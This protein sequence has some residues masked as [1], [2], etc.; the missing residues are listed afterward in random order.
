MPRRGE[1]RSGEGLQHEDGQSHVYAATVPSCRAYDPAFSYEVAVIVEDG[2]R[3]MLGEGENAFYYVT[4]YNENYPQ[5]A[6]PAGVE[7]G[8][9][10]GMYRLRASSLGVERPCVQLLGSGSLLREVLAAAE[11]LE[12]EFG[13]AADVWSVTSFGE[14]RKDGIACERWNL[15]HP[16]QPARLPYVAAQLASTRGP[17]VAAS[18]FVRA[19]P[20]LIRNWVPRSYSVLGTDGFGRSDTRVALRD[21]FEVD[22]RYIVLA[23]LRAL[24][25]DGSI[26]RSVVCEAVARMGI[27]PEKADPRC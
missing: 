7:E 23:A 27:N 18:D 10:R 3:H 21:F 22:A 9:R 14:L 25:E 19:Y 1:R 15:L 20:D 13:V 4:L 8:I 12:T 26:P 17:V 24:S 2:I 11:R 6:M 5:P 16:D